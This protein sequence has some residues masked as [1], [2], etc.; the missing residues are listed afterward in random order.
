M[1]IDIKS[2]IP[3]LLDELG[4]K[5]EV[6]LEECGMDAEYYASIKCPVDTGR[7][8]ASITHQVT[9]NGTS[10]DMRVGTNVEYAPYVELGT[11]RMK[12]RP[13]I[14]PSITEHKAHYVSVIKNRLQ[15]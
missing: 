5:I 11:F 15:G 7:L 2:H 12:A 1:K 9:T 13:F 8:R 6:A 4:D 3:E 10:G 14:K